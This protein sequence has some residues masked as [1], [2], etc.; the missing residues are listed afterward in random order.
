MSVNAHA[1]VTNVQNVEVFW[2]VIAV[3]VCSLN[4]LQSISITIRLFSEHQ[5][6]PADKMH[7]GF[8]KRWWRRTVKCYH[9]VKC[10][11]QIL[12]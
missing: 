12:V 4:E 5:S 1:T 11:V 3:V 2:F 8:T 10:Y 7:S 6:I 9:T